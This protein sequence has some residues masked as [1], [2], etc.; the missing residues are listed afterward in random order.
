MKTLAEIFIVL[1]FLLACGSCETLVEQLVKA[2]DNEA[3]NRQYERESTPQYEQFPHQ[4]LGRQND[5][6][7][8]APCPEG[9][10]ELKTEGSVECLP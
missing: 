2:L 4:T 9:F 7:S 1:L 5:S 8:M 6:T 3:R 10:E